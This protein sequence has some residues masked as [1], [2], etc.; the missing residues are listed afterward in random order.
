MLCFPVPLLKYISATFPELVNAANEITLSAAVDMLR[1][2]AAHLLNVTLYH[3]P[4]F[5]QI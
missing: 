4:P 2:H 5:L 3:P 1:Q